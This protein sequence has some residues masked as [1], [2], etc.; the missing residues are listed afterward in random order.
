MLCLWDWSCF[1]LVVTGTLPEYLCVEFSII[2]YNSLLFIFILQI[3]HYTDFFCSFPPFWFLIF[4]FNHIDTKSLDDLIQL[5]NSFIDVWSIDKILYIFKVHNLISLN[6]CIGPWNYH[7]IKAINIPITSKCFLMSF[8]F[9]YL[10]V[11]T[12]NIRSNQDKILCV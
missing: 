1:A 12:L 5:L 3:G 9:I 6:I 8:V 2:F 7:T 11:R 4:Y 10:L